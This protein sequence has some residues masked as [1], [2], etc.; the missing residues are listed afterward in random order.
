MA[1]MSSQTRRRASAGGYLSPRLD[2]APPSRLS[3]RTKRLSAP[4]CIA[5]I[6]DTSQQAYVTKESTALRTLP[7]AVSLRIS[8]LPKGCR[9]TEALSPK[10]EPG[11]VCV[12]P[13]GFVREADLISLVQLK[14]LNQ[15][16][17]E[18]IDQDLQLLQKEREALA[19]EVEQIKERK[20]AEEEEFRLSSTILKNKLESAREAVAITVESIDSLY[21]QS[22]SS[23]T[24]SSHLNSSSS[25][26]HDENSELEGR[27]A[28]Q[29][30]VEAAGAMVSDLLEHWEEGVDIDG[31]SGKDVKQPKSNIQK[32]L[33][34]T[35]KENSDQ[36]VAKDVS[37]SPR[38]QSQRP[39]FGVCNR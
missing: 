21:A 4:C 19:A 27:L 23:M 24:C 33:I 17:G 28:A 39:P 3:A 5:N 10:S 7:S 22:D 25:D 37:K 38:S 15:K 1:S 6:D 12:E 35:D 13:R 30:R 34:F 36:S 14:G 26:C 32:V 2:N 11:W 18:E 31:D 20:R 8:V 9:V 29:S 16:G